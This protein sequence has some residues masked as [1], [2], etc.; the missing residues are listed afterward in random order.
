MDLPLSQLQILF[1][2]SK[3]ETTHL[4]VVEATMMPTEDA[5][6]D[7]EH[8]SHLKSHLQEAAT[9]EVVATAHSSEEHHEGL[10]AKDAGA[11]EMLQTLFSRT[12]VVD[13]AVDKDIVG[14]GKAV[15]EDR[16]LA[17]ALMPI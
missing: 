8:A 9:T 2:T 15:W 4:P 6:P 3:A 17:L 10:N 13:V 5:Y 7:F 16:S 12:E 11:A 14:V 1:G